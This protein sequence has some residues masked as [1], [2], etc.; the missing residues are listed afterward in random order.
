MKAKKFWSYDFAQN[1]ELNQY[2]IDSYKQRGRIIEDINYYY[3]LMGIMCHPGLKQQKEYT[4]PVMFSFVNT[5][6]DINTLKILFSVLPSS[7]VTT[8]KFS[9]NSFVITN[10]EYLIET[11]LAK[12]NNVC[13]FIFEWNG[14]VNVDGNSINLI[15]SEVKVDL[16]ETEIVGMNRVK[17]LISKLGTSHRI[18]A[19][20]LRGNGIGDEGASVLFENLKN[21]TT[22][23]ILN[24]YRNNITSKSFGVFCEMID[25]NRILEDINIGG[26]S[27]TD[28]DLSML[29]DRIGKIE[30]THDEVENYNK[31]LKDREAIIEKNKKLKTQKKAEEPLP[32]IPEVH[33]VDG[34]FYN[35]L[36]TK[37]RFL[38][39]F[40]NQ[41]SN[42]SI[43]NVIKMLESHTELTL[44][45]D[46]KIFSKD[47][48]EIVS[49]KF[50]NRIYFSK[51]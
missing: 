3:D 10:M 8:L 6:V 34:V 5:L 37:I 38:N 26:N 48:I 1:F 25:V 42:E 43:T 45:I 9:S 29:K 35:L 32:H 17:S 18:E 20:C 23:R 30:M 46:E 15:D 4:E 28:D 40:Q 36:N 19:L 47:E 27:L 12:P 41:F 22:L 31:K 50:Y 24:V 33:E 21:N 11:L 44:V 51:N 39:I 14:K 16:N 49:N 13:N 7:K 2:Q